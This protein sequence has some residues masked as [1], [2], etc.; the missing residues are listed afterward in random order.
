[1]GRRL[2]FGRF[3]EGYHFA[4]CIRRKKIAERTYY[5]ITHYDAFGAYSDGFTPVHQRAAKGAE[6]AVGN[7][8]NAD[9]I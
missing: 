8:E 7:R 9:S 3:I 1:M 6:R 5:N 2:A 4:T